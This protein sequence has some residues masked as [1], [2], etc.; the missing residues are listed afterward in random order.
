MES[1]VDPTRNYMNNGRI[2]NQIGIPVTELVGNNNYYIQSAPNIHSIPNNN[3]LSQR[4]YVN[5]GQS[6]IENQEFQFPLQPTLPPSAQ[7]TI[8]LTQN[9]SNLVMED[10]TVV[11]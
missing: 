6:I 4:H 5:Y 8:N 7:P 2:I 10:K 3:N 11:S 1:G 9:N